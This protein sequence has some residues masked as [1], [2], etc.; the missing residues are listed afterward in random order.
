MTS[1]ADPTT[2][3]TSQTT[4][5][6]VLP[7]PGRWAIDPMHSRIGFSVRHAAIATVHGQFTDVTGSIDVAAETRDSSVTAT[8]QTAS[9]TTALAL[10]DDEVRGPDWLD[11][12]RFPV[13]E[14]RSTGLELDGPQGFLQGML[15]IRETTR[16][17]VLEVEFLGA[18]V[19]PMPTPHER[20]GFRATTRIDRRDFGIERNLP[21][22]A[23][24]FL[25]SY[26]VTV[27]LDIEAV[28]GPSVDA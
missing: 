21:I 4:A 7:T 12:G 11:V 15:T 28:R 5:G 26:A 3:T 23:G 18:S 1:T 17:V 19:L 16:P 27:T 13:L 8:V 2:A 20:L 25:V 24:G 22:P 9:V 14:F 10:R 6:R